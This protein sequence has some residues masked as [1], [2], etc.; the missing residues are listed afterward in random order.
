MLLGSWLESSSA[1]IKLPFDFDLMQ[2]IIDYLYTDEI[3]M[4]FIHSNTN[5]T[6]SLK[7]KSEKEIEVLFNLYVLS[8]QL[9][10]ER[11]KN[12]CEFKLAN[13]VNLKNVA[14]IFEFSDEFEA[15]QLKEF[16]MEFMSNNL[17]T[18]IESKL[19]ENVNLNLLTDLS[20]FYKNYF[21]LIDSRR[22]TPYSGGLEPEKVELIPF[23]LI[24][25]QKFVDG[26]DF[27]EVTSKKK[28]ST[29]SFSRN[30]DKKEIQSTEVLKT[31]ASGEKEIVED[32][33]FEPNEKDKNENNQKWEKVKKK[34]SK[35]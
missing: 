28:I 33:D 20:N 26:D 5:Y 9:L 8:D 34:V 23:D 22:I 32:A 11:L 4:D 21:P 10:V 6:S 15:A 1:S 17:V 31:D 19:L 27:E 7:S 30:E 29:P 12:L 35:N 16:C 14:E 3:Q 13:L 25:D 24:Y 18:L 2:I